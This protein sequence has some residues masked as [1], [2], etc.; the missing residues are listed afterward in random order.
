MILSLVNQGNNLRSSIHLALPLIWPQKNYKGAMKSRHK[1][2]PQPIHNSNS[3]QSTN[4]IPSKTSPPFQHLPPIKMKFSIASLALVL[5]LAVA[6]PAPIDNAATDIAN[7]VVAHLQERGMLE[8]RSCP[9]NASCS[10][11][12]CYTIFCVPGPGPNNCSRSQVG[13]SC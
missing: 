5:S 2:P 4:S 10:N 12:K 11:G 6:A 8:Q 3:K 1:P 13:G 9:K 7:S